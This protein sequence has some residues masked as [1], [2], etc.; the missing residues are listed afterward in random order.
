MADIAK[1]KFNSDTDVLPIFGDINFEYTYTDEIGSDGTITRTIVA[2][3][4]PNSIKFTEKTGLIS[5][6]FIDMTEI[7]SCAEMFKGCINLTYV[8]F[9]SVNTSEVTDMRSMFEGCTGFLSIDLSGLNTGNVLDMTNMF[10]GCSNVFSIDTSMINV[11]K[12]TS[13]NSMF[14]GC[15]SI[16]GISLQGWDLSNVVNIGWMFDGCTNLLSVILKGVDI[17]NSAT[18]TDMF[19]DCIIL[20]NV[21]MDDCSVED[22]N[23]MMRVLPE[24]TDGG[25]YKLKTNLA[26]VSGINTEDLEAKGWRLATYEIVLRYKFDK[27]VYANLIPEFNRF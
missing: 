16:T 15:A 9:N 22:I 12:A 8:D 18:I 19:K 3:S 13:L 20:N 7:T 24:R 17:P 6:E 14:Q 11:S 5:V 10:K 26:D 4:S 23:K 2:N 1:Y 27:S 21:N 25:D